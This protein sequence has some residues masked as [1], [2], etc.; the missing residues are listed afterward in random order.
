MWFTDK[1]NDFQTDVDCR[2]DMSEAL[3]NFAFKFGSMFSRSVKVVSGKKVVSAKPE[4]SKDINS[5]PRENYRNLRIFLWI[6]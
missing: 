5:F 1:P 4:I 2:T 3:R 6:N